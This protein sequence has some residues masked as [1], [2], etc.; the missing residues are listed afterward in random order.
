[1]N[2]HSF[3]KLNLTL[4]RT[5]THLMRQLP[6]HTPQKRSLSKARNRQLLID[7]TFE[8]VAEYGIAGVSFS[9]VLE[10]AKL[11]R[12][13]INLHFES[14]EQLLL[15][16]AKKMAENYFSHLQDY[17]KD[18]KNDPESQLIALLAADFDTA[19]LNSREI[20]VWFAFRGEARYN[21]KF[22]PYSDTR[23]Q[24][25]MQ[26]YD[27]IFVKLLVT[28]E[29]KSIRPGDLTSG[30]LA[31]TEGLWSDYFMHGD[32]FKADGARRVIY[33]YLSKMLPQCR[34]LA[35]LV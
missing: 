16:A 13:M 4:I 3:V 33:L 25:L 18:I 17:I 6:D 21:P 10:R 14:K 12:G 29:D 24:H 26:L 23:D 31:L 19:I 22:K 9:R 20:G 1:M 32:D 28:S 35:T 7:A 11:S 30:L 34:Q 5:D 27:D 8:V 15:A 2:V